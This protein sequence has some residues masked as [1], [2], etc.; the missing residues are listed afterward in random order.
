ME[1]TVEKTPAAIPAPNAPVQPNSPGQVGS[2][3]SDLDAFVTTTKS[4]SAPAPAPAAPEKPAPAPAPAPAAPAKAPEQP[5]AVKPASAPAKPA[6]PAPA[7]GRKAKLDPDDLLAVDGVDSVELPESVVNALKTLDAR[8]LRLQSA[9]LAQRLRTVAVEMKRKETELES[10]KTREDPEK[11]ALISERS[12]LQK[13]YEATQKELAHSAYLKSDEYIDKYQK[14]FERTLAEAYEL[15]KEFTVNNPDET[16]RPATTKDLDEILEAPRGA[17]A[18][19]AREKFGD[20]AE[21]ILHYARKLFDLRRDAARSVEDYRK[22]GE[23]IEKKRLAE[24]TQVRE[25]HQRIWKQASEEIPQKY[26]ELFGK[27]EDDPEGNEILD[28]AYA[29]VDRSTDPNL[30]TEERIARTAVVRHRAA[31]FAREFYKRKKLEARVSELEKIVSDYESSVPTS[32]SKDGAPPPSTN[33]GDDAFAELDR[34]AQ[35]KQ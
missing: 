25:T 8:D 27:H 3:E 18:R 15:V 16:T 29:E 1:S 17:A 2:W 32:G 13:R 31:A 33:E 5:A 4:G 6:E 26:P 23:E 21:D 9:K 7:T 24:Q 14:P 12:E 11:Q 34:I 22:Q 30:K 10:L 28:R 19:I 35:A 20:G